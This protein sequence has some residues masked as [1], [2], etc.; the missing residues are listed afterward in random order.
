MSGVLRHEA[1]H[2]QFYLAVLQTQCRFRLVAHQA[3]VARVLYVV[4][5]RQ[6]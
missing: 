1:C 4:F 3:R 6:V 2:V 5:L